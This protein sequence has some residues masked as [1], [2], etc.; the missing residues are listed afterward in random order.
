MGLGR[1]NLDKRTLAPAGRHLC[2]RV[3]A[4]VALSSDNARL[5]GALPRVG[6]TGASEGPQREALAWI[7]GVPLL[8]SVIVILQSKV[9][10]K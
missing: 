7:A 3:V 2:K 8:W 4:A 1:R 6:V 10:V 9:S 5:A